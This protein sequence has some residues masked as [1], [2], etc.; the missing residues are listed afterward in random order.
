MVNYEVTVY[1]GNRGHAS[2]VNN[3]HIKLVGADGESDLTWLKSLITWRGSVSTYTVSCPNS[4]GRLLLIEL[5]KRQFVL[6]PDDAWF[7]DKVEIKSPENDV[8]T[9]P[10]H[11][12]ISSGEAHLSREGTALRIFDESHSL[13]HNARK[14]ELTRRS[15]DYEWDSYAPGVPHT[16]KADGPRTLPFEVQFSFTKNT[17][18]QF[19]A[20]TGLFEL[21]LKGLACN[22]ENWKNLDDI[23]AV[24][25]NKDTP[26]SDYVQEHWMEDWLFA[27]QFLNGV[28]PTLIQRIKT[29]PENFPVTD[30]MVA[31]PDGSNLSNEL[32]QGNVYLCDYKNLDGI[33][34]HSIQGRQQHLVT[35]LVLLHKRPDDKLMPIAI[36]L[37]Q[38]PAKD[39]PIFLPTDSTYDWLTAKIFVRSAEFVEHELHAHLLRTHLLAE[40][41]AVS[42]LRNLPM[43][44]P[45]YKLLIP[46]TRYTM[47]INELARDKLIGPTGFFNNFA[48]SGGEALT[49]ILARSL[50]SITYRSLCIPDDIADRDLQDIPN[51]YYRDDGL[52]LWSIMFKF[53]QGVIQYYYKSDDEVQ[54]DS[55]LQT[56]IGDIFQYGFLSQPQSG[57]PQNFTTVPEL[58]KFVTMV[59]YTSS[60]QHAAVNGGQYDYGG[61]MPNNPATMQRPPP[62][63]KGTTSEATMLETLPPINVTVETMAILWLLSRKSSDFVP[64]GH[65]P[66]DHYTEATPRQ[67]QKDFKAEL[68]M[69][70][71]EINNRNEGLEIPYTYLNPEYIENSVSI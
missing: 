52:K 61:W 55:E 44:H 31:I 49:K 39:N 56:W 65:Y 30:E 15:A 40:I 25:H 26:L 50:S 71:I 54:R 23:N 11:C 35:P 53:V 59:M 34:A 27:Y 36:Q 24:F 63:K 22:Q 18:F 1:T 42:L 16:I 5:D 43:V 60:C 38:T 10:V 9:F 20:V 28:N 64:L 58:T 21:H 47:H 66:E 57:I 45:L 37:K 62:T 8:Y 32:K 46:H 3:V 48:A 7:P 29:L 33:L 4:L 14:K 51:F 70:S 2:T 17:E 68:D 41:F 69:L 13:G 12:W 67:L 6:F 19:T